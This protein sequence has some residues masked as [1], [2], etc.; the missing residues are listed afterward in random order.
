MCPARLVIGNVLVQR[1]FVTV[2]LMIMLY[3]QSSWLI[4]CSDDDNYTVI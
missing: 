4:A 3:M 2:I 1:N